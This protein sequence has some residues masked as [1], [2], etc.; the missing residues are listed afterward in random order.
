MMGAP[1]GMPSGVGYLVLGVLLNAVA[2]AAYIGA[3]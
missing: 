1:T 2:T 3:R